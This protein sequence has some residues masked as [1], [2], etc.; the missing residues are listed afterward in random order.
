MSK[1]LLKFY[2]NPTLHSEGPA[3]FDTVMSTESI[4]RV[5]TSGWI[6]VFGYNGNCYCRIV[7]RRGGRSTMVVFRSWPEARR[8]Y[9]Q[10]LTNATKIEVFLLKVR[11][12]VEGA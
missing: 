4:I 8:K 1:A 7:S 2:D 3:Y 5:T 9:E 10:W 6:A 12:R 11:P